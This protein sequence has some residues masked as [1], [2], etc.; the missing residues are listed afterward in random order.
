MRISIEKMK[1]FNSYG[2]MV[3]KIINAGGVK[4]G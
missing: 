2:Q 4:E 1:L 3:K